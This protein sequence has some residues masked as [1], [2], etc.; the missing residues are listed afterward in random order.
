MRRCLILED[1]QAQLHCAVKF[2][3]IGNHPSTDPSRRYALVAGCE[4][5][6]EQNGAQRRSG[7]KP[8]QPF[9]PT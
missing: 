7:C 3:R 9:V 5:N 2:L 4:M 1:E 8:S 6:H